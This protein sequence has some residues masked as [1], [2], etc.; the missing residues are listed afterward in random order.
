M[1]AGQADGGKSDPIL[2]ITQLKTGGALLPL[3]MTVT[4]RRSGF[5]GGKKNSFCLINSKP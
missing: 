4:Q 2:F 1:V 3:S 5:D